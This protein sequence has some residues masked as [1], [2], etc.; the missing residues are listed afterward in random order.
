MSPDAPPVNLVGGL[1]APLDEERTTERSV[2][3]SAWMPISRM[4][5]AGSSAKHATPS[6][7]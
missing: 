3:K 4:S 6:D 1:S 7:G 5:S 2:W